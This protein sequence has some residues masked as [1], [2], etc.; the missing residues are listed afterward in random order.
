M[1]NGQSF[2][3]F[4]ERL[5][6]NNADDKTPVDRGINI[7]IAQKTRHEIAFDNVKLY[8]ITSVRARMELGTRDW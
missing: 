6:R 2:R 4:A 8:S 1:Q 5:T 7:S 3:D